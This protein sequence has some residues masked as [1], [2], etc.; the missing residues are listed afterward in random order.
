MERLRTILFKL[1][2]WSVLAILPVVL[3]CVGAF[4]TML[5]TLRG[6][7]VI[8]P[9]VVGADKNQAAQILQRNR[10]QGVFAGSRFSEEFAAGQVVA[11]R[12]EAGSRVKRN[13]AVKLVVSEG[14]KQVVV[15]RLVGLT[16]KEAQVV[17]D[18][19]GLKLGFV[20]RAHALPS[21]REAVAQQS[22]EAG[23]THIEN[24][25]V[26]LLLNIPQTDLRYLMPDLQGLRAPEVAALFERNGFL[27]RPF[28]YEAAFHQPQ[29]VVL[30]HYPEA[31][32]PLG[33]NTPITLVVSR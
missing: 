25:Y 26:N 12:P 28:E 1:A 24:P 13:K 11:Q 16:I 8:V 2:K 20:S 4:L 15:P 7:E 23:A 22:P 3:L 9:N 5:F 6:N 19:S 27:L 33:R 29:G 21:P 18:Q 17:L 14:R 10:L 31:G 32:H 30:S